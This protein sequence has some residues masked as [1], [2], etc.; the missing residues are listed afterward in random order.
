MNPV[1]PYALGLFGVQYYYA[2]RLD[3]AV[4]KTFE[5]ISP[6]LRSPFWNS[7]LVELYLAQGRAIDAAA[8]VSEVTDPAWQSY[9]RA[10]VSRSSRRAAGGGQHG[11]GIHRG[12]SH[13]HGVRDR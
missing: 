2:G 4:A 7:Y 9:S 13:D 11:G 3:E 5:R 1:D 6:Y 12:V 8:M 10:L